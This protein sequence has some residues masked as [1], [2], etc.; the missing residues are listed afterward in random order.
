MLALEKKIQQLKRGI[1]NLKNKKKPLQILL[2]D[3]KRL[4][5]K[6]Y[7][8][9]NWSEKDTNEVYDFL[10]NE[11]K[12]DEQYPFF[13]W[14][15]KHFPD[16]EIDW[17]AIFEDFKEDLFKNGKIDAVISFVEWYKLKYLDDYKE[18]FEFI[19][20]DLCNYYFYK[21]D[22][23]ILQERIAFI[24]QNPVMAMDTLTVRLLY[25]L[26]YHGYYKSAISYA[27]AVWQPV[28]ESDKLIR[29]AAY[30][31]INTIYVNQL[32]KCYEARLNTVHFDEEG[33]FR[34]TLNMGFEDDKMIFNTV[35]K[36]LHEEL[37]LSE[38]K[39]SIQEGKDDHMLILN[40]HFLKHMLDSYQLPFVFSE[41]VWNFIATT[42]I[43]GRHIG[44]DNWFYI[45]AKTLH[46]HIND[47]LDTFLGAKELE[48]FGKV[49]GLDFVFKF[50][51]QQQLLSS[52]HYENMLENIS[53]FRNEMMRTVSVNLW[54][55]MF[56][57]NWPRINDYLANPSEQK[58]F[59]E[60][61][62]IIEKEAFGKVSRYL[63][64]NSI[65]DRIKN[66][67]KLN[68]SKQRDK[69]PLW[70]EN[71]PYIK[72]EPSIGRNDLCPCGSG[73]KYKKCCMNL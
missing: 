53:Y 54:Q 38:I 4:K 3:K 18:R 49:W 16:L 5:M 22:I 20:R 45:D 67:L 46:K 7:S 59:N 50:L 12:G 35:L 43:F 68:K 57:F 10:Y 21:N 56:V 64:L 28:N 66:E 27:E 24:K 29:F 36:S 8:T 52:E 71:T 51:H 9:I 2:T 44:V 13:D 19:E 1:T 25:Q 34:Q 11:L 61:Y 31:F 70:S 39:D 47:S 65:P 41:W 6:Q 26:I 17:L 14:L 60:T 40:I 15:M 62:C 55:M 63:S 69:L 73:K 58:L 72:Q 30:P 23:D 48:V 32:Q 42:K 37:N 33:L